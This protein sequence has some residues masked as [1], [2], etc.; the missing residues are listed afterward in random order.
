M[1]QKMTPV[2]I[3]YS[4]RG[5]SNSSNICTITSGDKVA[6]RHFLQI[7]EFAI[8]SNC[9]TIRLLP[10]P[11]PWYPVVSC[12]TKAFTAIPNASH[13]VG[14]EFS[15]VQSCM[16][17]LYHT[18]GGMK[19]STT[20]RMIPTIASIFCSTTTLI[21]LH[22]LSA[23]HKRVLVRLWVDKLL[24]PGQI[25]S[26]QCWK[27]INRTRGNILCKVMNQGQACICKINVMKEACRSHARS[28]WQMPTRLAHLCMRT[29]LWL[30]QM[31]T[32][33]LRA[34]CCSPP[35]RM[36]VWSLALEPEPGKVMHFQQ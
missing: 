1:L 9:L 32:A 29:L 25:W 27:G 7:I 12:E 5:I 24:S 19:W 18:L 14:H 4:V 6:I 28:H 10:E 22:L 17:F 26:N 33:P 21:R 35:V 16:R 23:K 30:S 36:A 13:A 15:A 20:V 2:Q 8:L 31:Q 11:S 3:V 34:Q